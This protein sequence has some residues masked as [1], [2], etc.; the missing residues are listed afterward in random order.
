MPQAQAQ[1][2]NSPFLLLTCK[3]GLVQNPDADAKPALQCRS[4][5]QNGM[6]AR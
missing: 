5:S 2:L 3:S 1:V 4:Q 6:K